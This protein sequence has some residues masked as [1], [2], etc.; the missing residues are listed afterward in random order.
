MVMVVNTGLVRNF[1][2]L[3]KAQKT[4]RANCVLCST[5]GATFFYKT[6]T[7]GQIASFSFTST[8]RY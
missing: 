6:F 5:A 3:C 1:G 2:E 4:P 7:M 8:S